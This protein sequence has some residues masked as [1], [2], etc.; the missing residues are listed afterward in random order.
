[1]NNRRNPKNKQYQEY[2]IRERGGERKRER[3]RERE[4]EREIER[5]TARTVRTVR[6]GRPESLYLFSISLSHSLSLYA[7]F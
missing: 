2:Y 7:S 5:E 3:E 4:K 6:T 1:M